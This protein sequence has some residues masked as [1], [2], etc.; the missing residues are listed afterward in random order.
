MKKTLSLSIIGVGF[1]ALAGQIIF[2]REFLTSFSSDELSIGLVLASWLVT[3][4]LGSFLLGK[5]SDKIKPGYFIFWLAQMLLIFLLPAGIICIRCARQFLQMN[6]GQIIPFHL[7]SIASFLI[8]LPLCAILGF[9]FSLSCKLY[10]S[11]TG[12]AAGSISRVYA[13]ESFGAMAGG[14]LVT[15]IL[16]RSLNNLQIISILCLLNAGLGL[17]FVVSFR[18]FKPLCLVF[19]LIMIIALFF[20][21]WLAG[22]NK[23]D[24]YLLS[25]QWPGY[26][27]LA[28]RNSLY[29]NIVLLKRGEDISFFENGVRLYTVP[30]R[31]SSEEAVHFTLLEHNAPGDILLIGGGSGGLLDEILKHPVRHVDYLELD[32]LIVKMSKEFLAPEYSRVFKNPKISVINLDGRYFIKS[33]G[34]K[35]DCIIIHLGD[36]YT[37]QVN[38]FYTEEFFREAAGCLN[39][40]GVI[41][42]YL[43]ASE[44]YINADMGNFL[45]SIYLT[46]SRQFLEIKVFPGEAA[47]FLASNSKGVLTYDYNLLMQRAKERNL[48]LKYVREYYLF[49]RLSSLKIDYLENLLLE[50]RKIKINYDFRPSAYYYGII[51]WAGRF[52]DSLFLKVLKFT[53]AKIIW[54]VLSLW[55]IILMISKRIRRKKSLVLVSVMVAGFSQSAIQV[56]LLFSFQIIYGYLFYK[57]G[58]IFTFFMMGLALGSWWMASIINKIRAS[59]RAIMYVQLGIFIFS[60]FLPV[61]LYWLS[62]TGGQF[63]S[64]FG[65]NIYFPAASL[66]SG[67]LGGLLFPL[68]N[69][70][71]LDETGRQEYGRVSALSYGFDLFGSCL[72]AAISAVFLIPLLGITQ[73]C[74]VL[75]LLNLGLAVFFLTK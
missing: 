27:I 32:A 19:N 40:N 29:G 9:M 13:L 62:S 5:F 52:K 45:R 55:L 46:L 43:N 11:E 75:A 23:L 49:S 63:V 7:V 66:V 73:T 41:S 4:A 18:K 16:V 50:N 36:P 67:L 48:D 1:T 28:S 42:F 39:K 12:S 30:D 2:V 22:P 57:L 69:K 26:H 60:L 33:Q 21:W 71:Y 37:A 58:V 10:A 6:P 56:I 25:K 20:S 65:A 70:I 68:A 31:L 15:F 44:S 24:T 38:R 74:L 35:Y 3:G 17:L 14:L 61:T 34:K 64:W 72:G 47:Y 53:S 8:L 51:S 54:L 59:L